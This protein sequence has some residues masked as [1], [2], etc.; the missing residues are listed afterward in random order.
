MFPAL[1]PMPIADNQ[2]YK[3]IQD[4][5]SDLVSVRANASFHCLFFSL[6][7]AKDFS[8][9]G[10]MKLTPCHKHYSTILQKLRYYYWVKGKVAY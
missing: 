7:Y 4:R 10:E 1:H 3:T 2:S 5:S 6:L 8:S 9:D